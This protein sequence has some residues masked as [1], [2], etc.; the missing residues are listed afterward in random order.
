[1]KIQSLIILVSFF[2]TVGKCKA[3]F[4][5]K[6]EQDYPD[7]RKP[8]I[9]S[10]SFKVS[11]NV[12]NNRLLIRSDSIVDIIKSKFARHWKKAEDDFYKKLKYKYLKSKNGS[13]YIIPT[14]NSAQWF[15]G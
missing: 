10:N 9:K 4:P 2:L 12:M 13:V 6:I 8:L 14:S 11:K 3:D 15:L 7:I 1:M 5:D